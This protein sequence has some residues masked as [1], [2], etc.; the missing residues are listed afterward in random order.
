MGEALDLSLYSMLMCAVL[1]LVPLFVV[2]YLKL[3]VVKNLL[4]STVRMILQ[5]FLVGFFLEYLFRY[6]NWVVNVVWFLVMITVAMLTTLKTSQL[7]FSHFATPVLIS[8]ILSN[9]FVVMYF[10]R[11]IVNIDYVFDAKYTIAIGGMILG[12]SL[13][14]NVVGLGDFYK[15]LHRDEQLYCYRLSLG[16]SQFEALLPFVKTSFKAAINPTIATM[17]TMGIVS[18]PG[19]MTGQILGGSVPLVAVKYQIAIVVAILASTVL[20]VGLSII[21]TVRFSFNENGMMKKNILRI[22]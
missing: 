8:F 16:A 9:F 20:S 10:N 18:L 6:N 21:S 19:M 15:S 11:F 17:A 5:L 1:L 2:W 12:N 13:R 3:G 4:V 14:A 22:K 7:R